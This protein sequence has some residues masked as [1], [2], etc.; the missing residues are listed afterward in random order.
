MSAK[1][2]TPVSWQQGLRLVG[3]PVDVVTGAQ[4]FNET[5]FRLQGKHIPLAWIRQ[6]D[7]RRPGVDRGVGPGFWLWFDQ[8]LRFDLDGLTFVNGRGEEI[9]YPFLSKDGERVMRAAHELERVGPTHYRVHPPGDA[10]SLE[11]RFDRELVAQP[12]SLF[13]EGDPRPPV[14]LQYDKGLL[15]A[16]QVDASKRVA[17]EYAGKHITGAVL[18]ESGSTDKQRLFRYRYDDRGRLSEVED[19]CGGILRYEYD[20]NNRVVRATDRRGYSFLHTYDSDGRCIHTRGEDGVE[21]YKFEYKVP[22]RLTVVTRAD[23][24]VTQYFYDEQNS[25]VQVIDPCGGVTAYLKDDSG[26]VVTEVDPNGNESEILYDERDQPYAKRDP[27]GQVI[28]LPEG[29]SP[30]PLS[31]RLPK[32]PVQWEHGDWPGPIQPMPEGIPLEQWLPRW[33]VDTWGPNPTTALPEPVMVRNV[34]GLPVREERKDGKTRRWAFDP[35]AYYRWHT[36]FDGKTRRYEYTSWNHLHREIDSLGSITEYDYT[37][38]EKVAAIVDPLGTRHDYAY[39]PKDRLTEIRRHGKVR[40]RYK[41]D[42]ADNLIEK[43]DGQGRPL[44][45]FAIGPGNVMKQRLLASGDVQDFEYAKDGRLIGAKN[46]AG[47]VAFAYNPIGRRVVDERDGKGVRHRFTV[48][49]LASTTILGKFATTYHRINPTTTVVLDPAGQTHRLRVAGPGLI[50]RSCS[51][52]VEELSHYD[53]QGR[54]LLKAAEGPTMPKG[55]A[56]RFE[57]SGEGDLLRRDDTL[58]GTTRYENDDAHRLA[59]AILPDGSQQEYVYD[60]AGNLLKAPG[61]T[62]RYQSGNR[63]LEAND[64]R[65]TYSDRDHVAVREGRAGRFEY[66]YDSRDLLI[67]IEGPGLSY[68]AIHDGLG[69]RTKKTVNGQTWQYYWDTD[70]LAAEVFPDGRLRVYVYPDAFAL[71]PMLFLDYDSVDADPASGKR[72]H[73]HT[74]HLGCPELVL[75]DAGKIVWRARIDAYGTA[76]VDIGQDFHQPLRWPGHY[77]DA[78]TGLHD[79]RFRTYSPELGRYLQCDPVG[80]EGGI[81][82]YAYTDNPLRAVDLRGNSTDCPNGADCPLRKKKEME[83]GADAEGAVPGQPAAPEP[84]GLSREEG[85]S[86]VDEIHGQLPEKA[87]KQSTTTL[88]QLEDGRLVVTNSD[89]TRPAQRD[90]AR[91]L[92]GKDVLIPDEPGNPGYIRPEARP[93]ADPKATT[94]THGESRGIQAGDQYG[95]PV[96]R[97]WSASDAS[98]GGAACSGCES[99]QASHNVANETGTQS[100]G[101]RFDRGGNDG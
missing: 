75:D 70:R 7:S 29:F 27:Q 68:Q 17:F 57:Y 61:L 52:D 93:L 49:L 76:R 82:L 24:A 60:R 87:A 97:Q 23:G 74:D 85:Q 42:A 45:T 19:A 56:R 90:K 100:Q 66:T 4:T 10:P 1:N 99:S 96:T 88:S 26:R 35:N 12:C 32:T 53:L 39:D 16:I 46:R 13:F 14:R 8:E 31:H 30:H 80:T 64:D 15:L 94:P 36:D 78:E 77:F 18:L 5:D 38:S 34:Q 54:C 67:G 51:N 89:G 81:N 95:S 47:K 37:K 79:N 3:D 59:K 43:L 2:C 62:A 71:V 41:Y 84:K 22:E 33:L 101:G 48:N 83:G 28:L 50:E 40:E 63:Q 58:L 9:G 98:H 73:L 21:E 91:E 69:R 11:F 44:L 55:W 20:K 86:A 6:Y 25:L 65:F 92:L 72:Y